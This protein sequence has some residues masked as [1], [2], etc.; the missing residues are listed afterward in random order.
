[1]AV[2]TVVPSGFE[3]R[4]FGH[5]CHDYE[6]VC[7]LRTVR[8]GRTSGRLTPTGAIDECCAAA[9]DTNHPSGAASE[10]NVRG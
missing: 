3:P 7:H 9:V 8:T 1:M 10:R 4:F 6:E 5:S 2:P